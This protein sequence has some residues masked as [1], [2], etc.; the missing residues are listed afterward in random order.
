VL[1]D[2]SLLEDLMKSFVFY[3]PRDIV[4]G[5]FYWMHREKNIVYVA[6]V[7]CTGH[8]VPGAF[9]SLI[10]SS[11]LNKIILQNKNVDL[12][13]LLQELNSEVVEI[14]NKK[15]LNKLD[16]SDGM[17]LTIVKI[18]YDTHVIEF[19]NAARSSYFITPTSFN[20]IDSSIHS[21]GGIYD[22]D[23]KKYGYEKFEFVKGNKV[24]LFSDGYIDQ[25]GG[26]RNKKFTSGRFREFILNNHNISFSEQ[27]EKFENNFHTWMGKNK[28]LDDVLVIGLEL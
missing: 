10:G 19:A 9:L 14:V 11:L 20:E 5:D 26:E 18:N 8:G 15:N 6:V 7:D 12:K 23:N 16:V 22:N 1:P 17:D 13:E 2:M 28:Q 21:I 24:Y 3:L 25:F 4:S 27:K